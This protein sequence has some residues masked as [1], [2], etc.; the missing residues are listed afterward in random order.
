MILNYI[1]LFVR[2]L[3]FLLPINYDIGKYYI[4]QLLS[5]EDKNILYFIM[6]VIMNCN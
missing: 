5:M 6:N 4:N 3:I 2:P 1:Y